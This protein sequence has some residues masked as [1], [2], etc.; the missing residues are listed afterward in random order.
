MHEAI[1]FLHAQ[2][3]DRLGH[4][5]ALGLSPKVW[6]EQTG[7]QALVPKQEWLDTLVW[8]HHLL[9][10]G[11]DLVGRMALEDKIQRLAW[12]V[13]VIGRRQGQRRFGT[14]W[15]EDLSPLTLY[16]CWRLR[17][18]DPWC[19]D[20][21][22]LQEGRFVGR[23]GWSPSPVRRRWAQVQRL[24]RQ[25][26]HKEVGA[27]NAYRLLSLY[28][29]DNA[30]RRKGREL[31]LIDMQEEKAHWIELCNQVQARMQQ[32]VRERQ[33]VIE[34]NPSVNRMIGPMEKLEQHHA[35]S[36]TL[37]EK[38]HLK[39]DVRVTVNTDNPAV[40]NTSLAH[41]YYLLGEVLIRRGVPEAEVVNWLEWLRDNGTEYSFVRQLPSA[42]DPE[43]KKLLDA[44]RR[45]RPRVRSVKGREAKFEVFWRQQRNLLGDNRCDEVR[46]CMEEA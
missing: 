38:G 43:M 39:R 6:A 2:P 28:W 34:V 13:Y 31:E 11:N 14:T 37:D 35:F 25:E 45:T 4:G 42:D 30:V 24:V 44:I 7:Y 32:E 27:P 22:E 10:P 18:L 33:L 9:G 15:A 29:F 21:K 12:E 26:V 5:I 1:E 17:Q 36:L 41:E 8:V 16:D 40:F 3:G 23:D 19:L 20:V 46:R